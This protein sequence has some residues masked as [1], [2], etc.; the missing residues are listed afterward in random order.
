MNSFSSLEFEEAIGQQYLP[1]F[2]VSATAAEEL[3]QKLCS[4]STLSVVFLDSCSAKQQQQLKIV[5][6]TVDHHFPTLMLFVSNEY[7]DLHSL[8]HWCWQQGFVNV[9]FL[10]SDSYSLFTYTHFPRLAWFNTTVATYFE[11]HY[12]QRNFKGYPIRFSGGIHLPRSLVFENKNGDLVISGIFPSILEL[13][14]RVHNGTLQH[15]KLSENYTLF[16]CFRLIAEKRV[17]L[18]SEQYYFELWLLLAFTLISLTIALAFVSWCRNSCW[19]IGLMFLEILASILFSP[20]RLRQFA[21]ITQFLLYIQLV[22]FGF[23]ISMLYL[24]FLSSIFSAHIDEK[25]IQSVA[26][27]E[28][29]NISILVDKVVLDIFDIYKTPR[30]VNERVKVVDH[31]EL[32]KRQLALDTRYA[33]FCTTTKC[34]V[35]LYQ[36]KFMTKPRLCR[37][38]AP[39][40][41]VWIGILIRKKTF[42]E[43][44]LNIHLK[45]SFETGIFKHLEEQSNEDAIRMKLIKFY[46]ETEMD[47]TPLSIDYYIVPIIALMV[48]YTI[49]SVAFV[50]ELVRY[51]FSVKM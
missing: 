29:R 1:K 12:G 47:A 40:L 15:V 2:I 13:F 35:I 28:Q 33:Y 30:D 5:S 8:F 19:H 14:A 11:H 24:A 31:A 46:T 37:I 17:D 36:Q 4:T 25:E 41:W 20:F 27:L 9:L 45:R 38:K 42:I 23:L 39:L 10:A 6:Y 51:R 22:V 34:N 26:D 21:G 44:L 43:D 48:G 7:P 16:D 3:Q 49:A 50:C 32:V 18:C